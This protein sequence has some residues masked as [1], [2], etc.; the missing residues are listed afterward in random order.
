M[1]HVT[2]FVMIIPLYINIKSLCHIPET[3]TMLYV[4]YTSLKKLLYA[5]SNKGKLIQAVCMK[6]VIHFLEIESSRN[7]EGT[8]AICTEYYSSKISVG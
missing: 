4:N 2:R 8:A 6:T 5:N 7:P 1:T 3:N